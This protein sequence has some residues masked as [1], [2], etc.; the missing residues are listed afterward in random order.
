MKNGKRMISLLLLLSLVMGFI[1]G[2]ALSAEAADVAEVADVGGMQLYVAPDGN[3]TAD[4]SI[5]APLKTLEGARTK[6]RTI[7]SSGDLPEGG[8]T[9]NLRAGDYKFLGES[10]ALS[11]VDSGTEN[12]PIVYQAY[13]GETVTISGNVTA[14]GNQFE[15][16]VNNG[17]LGR[18]PE[19]V[20][21]K[22]LVYD[23]GE[24]L[25]LKTFAPIPKIG[26][27]WP[28]QPSNLSV[29]VDGEVQ[30]LSRY[31]NSGF[32]NISQ[33]IDKGFVPRSHMTN[34][35]GT[36]PQCTKDNGGTRI[37]CK[38]GEANWVNQNGGVWTVSG[39]DD[40]YDLWSKEPDIWVSGY[41]CWA[42]ADD[43]CGISKVEKTDGGLKLT[44]KHPSRYGVGGGNAKKFYAYNLLCEIDQP[45]EWYLDRENAKLYLYPSKD[46]S[47]SSVELSVMGEPFILARDVQYVQFKNL[48]ITKGN[49]HGIQLI[50]CENT[51]VAGCTFSDLGQRAVVV[52]EV[53][54]IDRYEAVNTGDHGGSNNKILSCDILR[55]G[56]GGVYLAGGNRYTLT[57]GNNTV[58][59]CDFEDFSVVKRTYSPAV[60][61][62][63]CGN[64]VLRNRMHNAPH[65]A[66]SYDGNEHLIQGNEI[67][68]VCYETSD[69][70]AIYSCRT[71]SYRGVQIDN[72]YIHDLSTS[73]GAGSAAVYLDDMTSGGIITN[74]LFVNIAGRTMLM[75]GGR[76]NVIQNNIQI[77]S[78]NGLGY[79]YDNR[80]E[81]WAANA[82]TAPDGNNYAE[83]VKLKTDVRYDSK[84]WSKK[85]PALV[86]MSLEY[87]AD[88]KCTEALKP[89]GAD[90]QNNI[91]VGVA[92]PYNSIYQRVK[93]LGN[94]DNNY[95]YAQ[96]TDIGFVDVA[97]QNF[98]V[99]SDSLIQGLLGNSYFDASRAGL[100][101]DEY[102]TTLG[103]SVEA[104]KLEAPTDQAKN[105]SAAVGITFKWAS[106]DNTGS[107]RLEIAKEDTF[108]N[109]VL[110]A[111]VTALQYTATGLEKNTT[112][113][114]RVTAYEARLGGTC[115]VSDV[116]SFITSDQ[117]SAV[118]YEGFGDSSFSGWVREKGTP[119]Q[120]ETIARTGRFGY[121]LDEN[122]DVIRR[123]FAS[124]QTADISI[125]MYDNMQS[126]SQTVALANV[127]YNEQAWAAIGVN[128]RQKKDCYVCRIGS[129]WIKTTVKRTQGWHELTWKFQNAEAV[130][131][132]DGT[133]VYRLSGQTGY[134]GIEI[135]DF[136][137]DSG[138]GGIAGF[139]FDDI[140]IGSPVLQ[141]V[142]Q[143]LE[144]DQAQLTLEVGNAAQL[145][146]AQYTDVDV[147]V[148]LT[149][150]A[151]DHEIARVDEKGM[152]TANRT[153]TTIV[154]VTAEG[155]PDVKA[156]CQVTVV[157]QGSIPAEKITIN[158]EHVELHPFETVQLTA[159]IEPEIAARHL[160]TWTSSDLNVVGV[161]CS[162]K[163]YARS[164]GTAEITATV[165]G[166]SAVVVVTVQSD[167]SYQG[168]NF[169]FEKGTLE[170]WGQYPGN[171]SEGIE[172]EIYEGEDCAT[173]NYC[174]QI[175]TT[176]TIQLNNGKGYKHKGIQYRLQREDGT[177]LPTDT[178]FIICAKVKV[179][180]EKSHQMGIF[181]ILRGGTTN[182]LEDP[183]YRSVSE[184][185]GWVELK[186]VITPEILKK[187]PGTTMLD[188]IIG[189]QNT[190][191]SAGS[192]LVDDM[193]LTVDRKMKALTVTG[194][195]GGGQYPVGTEV[196]VQAS[197]GAGQIFKGWIADGIELSEEEKTAAEV[198]FTM[199]DAAVTLRAKY[200]TEH[201]HTP[202]A[203]PEKAAT[204]NSLGNVAY[205]ICSGEA[206]KGI[207]YANEA[208]T[209]RLHSVTTPVDPDNHVGGTELRG[210]K[211]ATWLEEGYTGDLYCKGCDTLLEKGKTT[212]RTGSSISWIPGI[213]G[214]VT[215]HK[216]PFTDVAKGAWYY[217]NVYY[218]WDEDLI[219]GV[220]VDK[221]QPDGSLTV[222]QAIKL[223]AA[224]HEK[225]NRGYV[226]LQ[227]GKAN[228]YDTYVD[229]AVNNS[230]IE[231]KYQ[232]YTKVQMNAAITRN[233]FVHIFHGAMGSYKAINTLKNN[234]IPDV[235]MNDVYADEIY[236]FYRA[237]IL[238]G[239]DGAGT[240]NGKTTIKR[241]EVAAILIRMFDT[242]ARKSITLN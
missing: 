94:V 22:V 53:A 178:T 231:S 26:Y 205:W 179:T 184:S 100:Y 41:F 145:H 159:A 45:G 84:A 155:Y 128:V 54:S 139:V 62:V 126:T 197:T 1:P 181:T 118:L 238:T 7:K 221:Y 200:D 21:D 160:I 191:E 30:T 127:V 18:L 33:V 236:D 3:D 103:V 85:Y 133:E 166:K 59:N 12:S 134:T 61:V 115:A 76:D 117:D 69:V 28:D 183:E 180:D 148:A 48:Q 162:G 190:T 240:F 8:I 89:A 70:G 201:T 9:V 175:V 39:L 32:L 66:I 83:W 34:P 147:D 194:G 44:A 55:T 196:L 209:N 195:T 31:P 172:V 168:D 125:W 130:L 57:N 207:Y 226:T 79:H 174:A 233:E 68:N 164:A 75:G 225:L 215:S 106:V 214:A 110:Q 153:G 131:C 14:A 140:Q 105:L 49:S 124:P 120:T 219:D 52:G 71:W 135:G 158:P 198:S 81:G 74:N 114:W 96:G 67:F 15:P 95:S 35:D 112:Y 187:Y 228:W 109:P 177:R 206:C 90:I 24:N 92:T 230:I 5:T 146:A 137:N 51:M 234:A 142:P 72:N 132:I 223:A 202:V 211:E 6:I 42:Y 222:A 216:L 58:E 29:S 213:L 167:T 65:M 56:Q 43:N 27:G 25:G 186:T 212:P 78:G 151:Q 232:T 204:C 157:E 60:A 87:N 119:T 40:K 77:N 20:R 189:N 37:P 163:L 152:V 101:K 47:K 36:C 129:D 165:D 2:M 144:L 102:R 88:G 107:Y 161:D 227:N 171:T 241:S 136:W 17:I 203:V 176:D 63:G 113:Y 220:T 217:E 99:K 242:T 13:P 111:S 73:G 149:W 170:G 123:N 154:T 235:K 46:I 182:G 38:I 93:D 91:C 224:L 138:D 50:D 97:A 141:P 98:A 185:D 82:G 229:Y 10:F 86:N 19:T 116:R 16:V 188:F 199:P 173:G 208:C 121:I 210:Q 108:A 80:G 218:A 192:Y 239:S 122:A 4:G 143:R 64:K 104:P 193:V 237:G 150:S 23:L 169:G 156:Q 11:E